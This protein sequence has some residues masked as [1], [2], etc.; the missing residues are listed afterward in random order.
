MVER[1]D[2]KGGIMM[3]ELKG[4][5]DKGGCMKYAK[6]G[7]GNEGSIVMWLETKGG[8]TGSSEYGVQIKR[9]DG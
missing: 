5:M 1:V 3:C 9:V 4:R 6:G 2:A 7:C 8:T